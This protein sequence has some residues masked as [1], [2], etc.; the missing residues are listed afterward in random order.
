MPLNR[1]LIATVVLCLLLLSCSGP[2]LNPVAPPPVKSEGRFPTATID[3]SGAKATLTIVRTLTLIQGYVTHS[4]A[5]PL[6]FAIDEDDPYQSVIV[7][8]I[9]E[10]TATYIIEGSGTGGTTSLTYEYPVEYEVRGNLTPTR[11]T[12]S[13]EQCQ[14]TLAVD[15]VLLLSKEVIGH[16]S[17]LGDIPII[18]GEDQYTSFTN[19]F[20]T[21]IASTVTRTEGGYEDVFSIDDWCLPWATGCT[22]GCP[23]PP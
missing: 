20:F 10:G 19:L 5:I 1:Q 21:E 16:S 7:W 9:G 12:L 22:Y 11:A 8:G 23:P 4:A 6:L 2:G 13:R 3:F 15:E 18:G 17:F 14:L